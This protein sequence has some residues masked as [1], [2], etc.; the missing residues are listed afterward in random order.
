LRIYK[1]LHNLNGNLEYNGPGIGLD[2]NLLYLSWA[3]SFSFFFSFFILLGTKFA[4]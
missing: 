1:L 3:L 4:Q 2:L